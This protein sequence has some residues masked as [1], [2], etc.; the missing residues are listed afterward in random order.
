MVIVKLLPS[1]LYRLFAL[2]LLCATAFSSSAVGKGSNLRLTQTI[3]LSGV[4]GR[5]DHLAFDSQQDRL[6]VAALGNNTVEVIDIRSGGRIHSISGLGAPQ[7]LACLSRLN[8]LFVANDQGGLLKIYD[9]GSFHSA[10]EVNLQD[11]ADNIRY[12]EAANRVYVGFG[13]GGMGI[14]SA[15]GK[16][17]GSIKLAAHPEAFEL[18]KNGHRIFVNLPNRREVAVIDRDKGEVVASWKTGPSAANFP[19]TL[20]EAD[21]RL[22]IGCR[23]APKLVVLNTDSGEVTTSLDISGDPDDLF[24]DQKRHCIYAICGAGKIDLIAQANPNS[25]SVAGTVETAKGARTG[26]FVPERDLLFVAVPRRG[27]QEAEIRVY[28]V[29]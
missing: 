7:G 26:L 17:L 10:G 12:D 16:Q 3:P 25:Y 11:D 29:D 13:Q 14:V 28:R 20:D 21:H 1:I 22:L 8:R 19:M 24:Y 18:E 2:G 15:E 27:S 9:A 5:I 6:F 23:Q 4:G